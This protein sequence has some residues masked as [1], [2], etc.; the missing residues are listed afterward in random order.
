[1][2]YNFNA[3]SYVYSAEISLS[4]L[5]IKIK[6]QNL[7]V[8]IV[9]DKYNLIRTVKLKIS[10]V[11]NNLKIIHVIKALEKRVGVV[12]IRITIKIISKQ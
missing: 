3:Q 7:K 8:F 5:L 4:T 10:L 12:V 6:I 1:L 2:L 9:I 11:L